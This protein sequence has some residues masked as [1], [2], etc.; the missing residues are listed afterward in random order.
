MK[1]GNGPAHLLGLLSQML[2][3]FLRVYSFRKAL[4]M[5]RFSCGTKQFT[6]DVTLDSFQQPTCKAN[7]ENFQGKSKQNEVKMKVLWF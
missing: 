3:I 7:Q 6:S 5:P 4:C 2:R 1:L